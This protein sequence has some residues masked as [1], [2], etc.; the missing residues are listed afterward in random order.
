M[1]EEVDTRTERERD[2]ETETERDR[3]DCMTHGQR[4]D[5]VRQSKT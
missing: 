2:R 1:A 4:L 3:E 5:I